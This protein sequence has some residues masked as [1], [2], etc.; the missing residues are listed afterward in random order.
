MSSKDSLYPVAPSWL[1]SKSKMAAPAPAISPTV[2]RIGR[3]K[4]RR[5]A[6]PL[7]LHYFSLHPVGYRLVTWPQKTVRNAEMCCFY[8]N[9]SVSRKNGEGMDKKISGNLSSNVPVPL[10]QSK[11]WD[12]SFCICIFTHPFNS[13]ARILYPL[14]LSLNTLSIYAFIHRFIHSLPN[15]FSP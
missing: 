6:R 2:Q 3:S 15:K 12:V 13:L 5:R 8:L 9:S 14:I 4:G 10:V 7:P 11:V 1:V